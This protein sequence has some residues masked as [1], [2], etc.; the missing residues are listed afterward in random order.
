MAE[1]QI[2]S[3]IVNVDVSGTSKILFLPAASNVIGQ[4][5][6][7]RDVNGQCNG[8]NIIYLSTMN[9]ETIDTLSLPVRLN[10]PFQSVQVIAQNTSNYVV[11]Q[12][13]SQGGTWLS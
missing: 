6:L 1:F 5:F 12:N 8:L 11:V 9:G 10:N 13:S 3:P 4:S 7:I 2:T